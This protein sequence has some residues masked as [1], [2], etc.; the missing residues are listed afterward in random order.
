MKVLI[1][2]LNLLLVKSSSEL[3]LD[4]IFS[5]TGPTYYFVGEDL[6]LSFSLI[7]NVYQENV[8]CTKTQPL[9][10]SQETVCF[11]SSFVH[12]EASECSLI[13][14]NVDLKD[15]GSYNCYY[16]YSFERNDFNKELCNDSPTKCAIGNSDDIKV[17][18]RPEKVRDFT[19]IVDPLKK[20]LNCMWR[21]PVE[22]VWMHDNDDVDTVVDVITKPPGSP[23]CSKTGCVWES[24]NLTAWY[25]I[26][27]TVSNTEQLV[28]ASQTYTLLPSDYIKPHPVENL[29]ASEKA[30]GCVNLTWSSAGNQVFRVSHQSTQDVTFQVTCENCSESFYLM[31]G[32]APHSQH[33]FSVQSF[34]VGSLHGYWSD[35][36]YLSGFRMMEAAPSLGPKATNGSFTSSSCSNNSANVSIYWQEVPESGRNGHIKGYIIKDSTGH[37]LYNGPSKV[38][39][40]TLP[41]DQ[42]HHLTLSAYNSAGESQKPTDVFVFTPANVDSIL[43]SLEVASYKNGSVIAHWLPTHQFQTITIFSCLQPCQDLYWV[44]SRSGENFLD[45]SLEIPELNL[46]S[47]DSKR[48]LFGIAAVDP[49]SNWSSPLY[50]T[51]C[52]YNPDSPLPTPTIMHVKADVN[53]AII[54]W[55]GA[56]CSYDTYN[57]F[58]KVTYYTLQICSA[59]SGCRAVNVTALEEPMM[60]YTMKDLDADTHYDVSVQAWSPTSVGT[61]VFSNFTTSQSDGAEIKII[62]AVVVVVTVSALIIIVVIFIRKC[63]KSKDRLNFIDPE[64]LK[65]MKPAD[66][67]EAVYENHWIA[68]GQTGLAPGQTGLAPAP[69]QTG[70]IQLTDSSTTHITDSGMTQLTDSD[71]QHQT[72]S[73]VSSTNSSQSSQTLLIPLSDRLMP[74]LMTSGEYQAVSSKRPGT[75]MTSDEYQAVPTVCLSP[76]HTSASGDLIQEDVQMYIRIAKGYQDGSLPNFITMV[77]CPAPGSSQALS[78]TPSVE[79]QQTHLLESHSVPEYVPFA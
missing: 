46:Q 2:L 73:D 37:I 16:N 44:K 75:L 39:N 38:A 67:T 60:S 56:T 12:C 26:T 53:F 47:S 77:E 32:L 69:G 21:H 17:Q 24:V 70:V 4:A 55:S 3:D 14:P 30:S 7:E 63:R 54:N 79:P 22:Y 34:H 45:V 9:I 51:P 10:G 40:L 49:V 76:Q 48:F 15:N 74:T 31:C 13:V 23:N 6:R 62:V 20:E 28:S 57:K 61:P 71:V 1:I 35:A 41:C 43:L 18:Y 78:D 50:W 59:R 36:T 64:F 25:D 29:S 42:H 5:M 58:A 68:P 19:C 72:D 33:N 66:K 27:V 52:L 8:T 65:V 11:G